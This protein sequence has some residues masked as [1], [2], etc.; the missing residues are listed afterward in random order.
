M[1]VAWS[2][3]RPGIANADYGSP[4]KQMMRQTL[5]F[6]PGTIHEAHLIHFPEPILAPELSLCGGCHNFSL[7]SAK[8]L[9]VGTGVCKIRSAR[10]AHNAQVSVHCALQRYPFSSFLSFRV[11]HFALIVSPLTVL[12]FTARGYPDLDTVIAP[13]SFQRRIV[14][15]LPVAPS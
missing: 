15:S 3:F 7:I 5:V 4:I 6:H 2:Q 14:S 8:V 9:S 12:P 11:P 13:P 10:G 1:S